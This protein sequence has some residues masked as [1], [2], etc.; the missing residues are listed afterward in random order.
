MEA[1]L[2]SAQLRVT[3]EIALEG[4]TVRPGG[5]KN[6]AS[7]DRPAGWTQHVTIGPPFLE[8][9]PPSSDS[10]GSLDG[11]RESVPD[12]LTICCQGA[13]SDGRT[14]PAPAADE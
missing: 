2:P 12:R 4:R 6:L 13:S 1:V 8:K 14:R 9:A 3:R 5:S 10:G 7:T 11:L